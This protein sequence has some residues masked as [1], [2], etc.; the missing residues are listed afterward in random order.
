MRGN[1]RLAL[2]GVVLGVVALAAA[3][4]SGNSGG[5]GSSGGGGTTSATTATAAGGGNGSQTKLTAQNISWDMTRLRFASGAKVTV[6]V[7]NK[8][9]VEHNFTFT[10]AKVAK[11]I[12]GG[13]DA[14]VSFTAPAPG[15]YK[16]FCKYH[17]SAMTGTVTVT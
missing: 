8:D 14:T 2:A 9:T 15:S 12:E 17:P 1:G 4:C 13:E 16:F 5:G 11:D 3:G 7:T 10:E 6:E